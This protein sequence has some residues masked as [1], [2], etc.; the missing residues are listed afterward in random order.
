MADDTKDGTL[1]SNLT[2]ETNAIRYGAGVLVDA[3]VEVTAAADAASVY[4]MMRLPMTARIHGTSR[5]AWDD[6]ASSG[7]PTLDIGL[8]AVDGNITTDDDAI[9]DGLDAATATVFSPVIK[10]IANWGKYLW[11]VAGL[12]ANPGGFAD[13]IVTIKDAAT[14]TGGTISLCVHYTTE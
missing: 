13:V 9:N 7:A 8:R 14:N 2:I 6:L 5:M 10:D 4:T 11:E 1:R 12:S 3:T